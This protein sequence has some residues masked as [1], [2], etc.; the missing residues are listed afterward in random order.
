MGTE[1]GSACLEEDR[2]KGVVSEWGCRGAR[3]LL[4]S[5]GL[6]GGG[7]GLLDGMRQAGGNGNCMA[8]GICSFGVVTSCIREG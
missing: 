3:Q 4:G 5:A 6:M 7:R 8:G 2:M 1:W